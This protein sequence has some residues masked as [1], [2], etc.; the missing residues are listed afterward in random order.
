MLRKPFLTHALVATLAACA[1]SCGD[2]GGGTGSGSDGG[3]YSL[4][5]DD[6]PAETNTIQV[7][8]PEADGEAVITTTFTWTDVAGWPSAT[9]L[10]VQ[11]AGD[12]EPLLQVFTENDG[13]FSRTGLAVE[14]LVPDR[15]YELA[16][17]INKRSGAVKVVITDLSSGNVVVEHNTV[18]PGD[19]RLDTVEFVTPSKDSQAARVEIDRVWSR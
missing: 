19:V 10:T 13:P 17:R 14:G 7:D 2:D 3:T 11:V 18:V 8:V 16:L 6:A 15:E 1:V 12:S 9:D 5:G 4:W